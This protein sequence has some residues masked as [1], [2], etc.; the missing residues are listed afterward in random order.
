MSSEMKC[1]AEGQGPN[2]VYEIL[3]VRECCSFYYLTTYDFIVNGLLQDIFIRGIIE[4][5]WPANL[6]FTFT[7]HYRVTMLWTL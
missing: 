4:I 5:M 2:A 3:W 1:N 7:M 6:H